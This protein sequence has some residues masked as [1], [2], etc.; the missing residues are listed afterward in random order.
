MASLC[1]SFWDSDDLKHSV[2]DLQGVNV[3]SCLL[4]AIPTMSSSFVFATS[5]HRLPRLELYLSTLCSLIFSFQNIKSLPYVHLQGYCICS[6]TQP[7]P[8]GPRGLF[9]ACSPWHQSCSPP[10]NCHSRFKRT[11]LD[12][13]PQYVTVLPKT[14][15][16]SSLLTNKPEILSRSIFFLIHSFLITSSLASLPF[17]SLIPSILNHLQFLGCAMPSLALVFGVGWIFSLT[18]LSHDPLFGYSFWPQDWVFFPGK[19]L[20]TASP[21]LSVSTLVWH[22]QIWL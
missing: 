6:G 11:F 14:P 19:L 17:W 22:W 9:T 2:H 20:Y 7:S 5:I 13:I 15:Q 10:F 1:T 21:A 3:Q 18:H 12:F 4:P 8:L 16:G